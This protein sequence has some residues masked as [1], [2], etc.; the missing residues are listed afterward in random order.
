MNT[1]YITCWWFLQDSSSV[2]ENP[3]VML[4]LCSLLWLLQMWSWKL[5]VIL[6]VTFRSALTCCKAHKVISITFTMAIPICIV[7]KP[8]QHQ[9]L[10]TE[11]VLLLW[12]HS[13]RP[14]SDANTLFLIGTYADVPM[15][16]Q[17]VQFVKRG[18]S[19]S[20]LKRFK[21]PWELHKAIYITLHLLSQH[22]YVSLTFRS[23]KKDST[24]SA[25]R[26]FKEQ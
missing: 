13:R 4:L 17:S 15:K 16:S 21:A 2:L 7:A 18:C 23:A 14:N 6:G 3:A 11:R 9:G 20:A 1:L 26:C 25:L 24:W 8:Q 5:S 22:L 19:W 10:N 12:L